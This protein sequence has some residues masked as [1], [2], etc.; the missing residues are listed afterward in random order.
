[1]V[2][3][4]RKNSLWT[5]KQTEN[6]GEEILTLEVQ[7]TSGFQDHRL[8]G[9]DYPGAGT[10]WIW[11]YKY[12]LTRIPNRGK[13]LRRDQ[14]RRF[15]AKSAAAPAAAIPSQ[16]AVGDEVGAAFEVEVAAAAKRDAAD[17]EVSTRSAFT[18]VSVT[19]P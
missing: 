5:E 17:E 12:S 1:M 4:M 16:T 8:S 2:Q 13:N 6:A 10:Y 3:N 19:V 11:S 14:L 7:G 9:L 15:T 18:A